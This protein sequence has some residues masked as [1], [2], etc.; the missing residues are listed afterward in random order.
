MVRKIS[1][2]QGASLAFV[3]KSQAILLTTFFLFYRCR[4]RKLRMLLLFGSSPAGKVWMPRGARIS[5]QRKQGVV[6]P[7]LLFSTATSWR[8][9][10]RNSSLAAR[11]LWTEKPLGWLG[12]MD[13]REQPLLPTR[14]GRG[15]RDTGARTERGSCSQEQN[16]NLN[17]NLSITSI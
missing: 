3:S 7:G 15:H 4:T 13:G 1:D 12:C 14:R 2:E 9:R 17:L 6:Q 11:G 8:W 5:S 16:L 10:K